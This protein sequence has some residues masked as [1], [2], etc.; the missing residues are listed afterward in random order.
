[1]PLFVVGF[2]VMVL[3]ATTGWVPASVLGAAKTLQQFLLATAMFALGLGV[4][5]KS[6][7]KLGAKPVL[8]GACSTLV[9]IAVV[10]TGIALGAGANI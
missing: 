3:V 7:V 5:V 9:I 8:L 1:M 6:L 10:L 2:I 4:H